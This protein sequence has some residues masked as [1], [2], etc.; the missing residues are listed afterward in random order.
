M[1]IGTQLKVIREL[2]GI[3]GKALAEK[4]GVV[5]S[6]IS[7]IE[8]GIT[9][10]SFDLLGR[11]CKALNI[12]LSDFFSTKFTEGQNI[13]TKIK[14]LSSK[15][16]KV[17]RLN[18]INKINSLPNAQYL[19]D[20]EIENLKSFYL[21]HNDNDSIAELDELSNMTLADK[22]YRLSAIYVDVVKE[23]DGSFTF[24]SIDSDDKDLEELAKY[25][26]KLNQEDKNTIIKFA[27]FLTN[28]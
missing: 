27:K 14:N 2:Y 7:K 4:V 26:F 10:P 8:S 28:S 6:Q 12:T 9:N 25:F 17:N 23:D 3:S 13:E 19:I 22:I 21:E 18:F 5:P 16:E 15:A 20:S 1:K 11:I 24:I